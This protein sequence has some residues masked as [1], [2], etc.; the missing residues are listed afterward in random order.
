MLAG[1]RATQERDRREDEALQSI[2]GVPCVTRDGVRIHLL[3]N[4]EFPDEAD[5]AVQHGAEGIGLFRSEYLLGRSRAVADRGPAGRGLP[6]PAR[7]LR[8]WPVTVRTWDVGAEDLA[9]GGPTS[10]EPRAR[11][12]RVAPH[13]ARSRPVPGPAPRAAARVGARARCA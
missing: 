4:A 1:F 3:A 12:A 5:T 9:P 7:A 13:R 2:R 10:A 8:P 11:A 6:R